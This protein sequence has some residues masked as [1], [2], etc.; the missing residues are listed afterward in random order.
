M[1]GPPTGSA[2]RTDKARR[3]TRLISPAADMLPHWLWAAMCQTRTLRAGW[4]ARDFA[5]REVMEYPTHS[6]LM[7]ANLI[8]LAHFSVSAAMKFANSAGE[9]ANTG[10]PK[11]AIRALIFGSARATLISLLSLSTI[12]IGVFLGVPTPTPPLPL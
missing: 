10:E 6:G 3:V 7:P 12:S 2:E 5:E 8:T 9:L 4:A 1:S 11:S